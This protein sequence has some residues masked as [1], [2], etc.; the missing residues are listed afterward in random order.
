MESNK[1]RK[2]NSFQETKSEALLLLVF[3]VWVQISNAMPDISAFAARHQ[4]KLTRPAGTLE[5]A[6]EK[7]TEKSVAR[8][9]SDELLNATSFVEAGK[10]SRVFRLGLGQSGGEGGDEGNFSDSSPYEG[11]NDDVQVVGRCVYL[12]LSLLSVGVGYVLI[13]FTG[14]S[15]VDQRLCLNRPWCS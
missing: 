13:G 10:T 5:A 4:L 11:Q 9:V 15:H 12:Y 7:A 14:R 2:L 8:R 1:R 3:C 6:V